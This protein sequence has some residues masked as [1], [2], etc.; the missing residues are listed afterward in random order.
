MKSRAAYPGRKGPCGHMKVLLELFLPRIERM[1]GFREQIRG[2]CEKAGTTLQ[3]FGALR[4]S[5]LPQR[6]Q[7]GLAPESGKLTVVVCGRLGDYCADRECLALVQEPKDPVTQ[8]SDPAVQRGIVRMPRPQPVDSPAQ[9]DAGKLSI[10]VACTARLDHFAREVLEWRDFYR[11][12]SPAPMAD[13]A[14]TP[15]HRR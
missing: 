9:R 12:Y 6:Y 1:R 14:T 13:L 4:A 10:A 8:P 5:A 11:Q 7:A 3:L 2:G 15:R